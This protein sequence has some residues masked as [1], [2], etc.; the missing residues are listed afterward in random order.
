[1]TSVSRPLRSHHQ[2]AGSH[3]YNNFLSFDLILSGGHYMDLSLLNVHSHRKASFKKKK[4]KG[5]K[6]Q[7]DLQTTWAYNYTPRLFCLEFHFETITGYNK[8]GFECIYVLEN[9]TVTF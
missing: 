7:L 6:K 3:L 9:E 2:T 1:M 4:K 8:N 5:E